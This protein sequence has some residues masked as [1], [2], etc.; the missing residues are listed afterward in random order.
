[1]QL[2][3]RIRQY[4]ISSSSLASPNTCSITIGV[5]EAPSF[6]AKD[7][8]FLGVAS[9][10]MAW[11]EAGDTIHA[12][13]RQSHQAFHLPSDPA[14]AATTPILMFCA[15]TGI[16]P[17]RGFVQERVQQLASGQKLA[18]AI[19]YL[20]VRREKD[21]P[22]R[23]ELEKW[24]DAGAVELRYVFSREQEK[25]KGCKYVQ[26]RAW[27]ERE[28]IVELFAQGARVYVCGSAG[29][30]EGIRE[31]AVKMRM[32]RS[33]KKGKMESREE[34]GKWWDSIRNERYAVDVFT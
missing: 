4:S 27:A 12:A 29:L 31:V 11:L 22:Y 24:Q 32:E 21:L 33:E 7:K 1:M 14:D 30:G 16:A 28:E 18:R 9:N 3:M 19:L 10:Y 26:D 2:P 6:A 13:V 20:G 34:A 8:R 5:L 15:G 23:S 17:F 25:S